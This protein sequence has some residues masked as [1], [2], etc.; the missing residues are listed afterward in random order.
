MQPRGEREQEIFERIR[1]T[2][3]P[4]EERQRLALEQRLAGQGRLG[5]QT[6]QFGGTP[7][8]LALAKAQEE[9]QNRAALMAMQQA[10]TEQQQ[11]FQQA[12]GLAGQTG[13]LAQIGS[14]LESQALQRGL[15]LSQLGLAG[16]QAGAG[17]EAQRLQ[18]L[19]GLQQADIGAA[20][21]QQALQQGGLGLAGGLFGLSSQAAGLPSQLQAGD[22]ANLQA[23][24]QTSYAPQAQLLN[25][26]Q[27]AINIA[28]IADIGRRTGA[29][30][31]GEAAASGLE[32]NLQT[33][34]QRA[35]LEQGL[36][37]S[38]AELAGARSQAGAGLFSQLAGSIPFFEDYSDKEWYKKLF[39]GS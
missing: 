30:L 29:G 24:M 35:Q 17:L 32:A 12:L 16:T 20:Q 9:A 2:Q 37:S 1:A 6:A 14:G 13:Q 7:E 25:A 26:L 18:Q 3:T 39:G 4:E 8:Q 36:F 10:G 15:G 21:A 34:L 38:L 5:V 28:S 33:A 27:P 19:L 23:L 22:I 11:Q 31:F